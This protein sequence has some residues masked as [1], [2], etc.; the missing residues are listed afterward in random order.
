MSYGD[1]LQFVSATTFYCPTFR[2]SIFELSAVKKR[3]LSLSLDRT[4]TNNICSIKELYSEVKEKS[5]GEVTP[6]TLTL[7]CNFTLHLI[8]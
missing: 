1:A 5:E 8:I 2:K 6:R 7:S 3:K 4:C